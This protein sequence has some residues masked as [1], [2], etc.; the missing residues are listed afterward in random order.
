MTDERY[1]KGKIYKLISSLTTDIY[2]G[3]TILKLNERL[4]KHK[5]HYKLF[6]ENEYP[7][8][9]SFRL[10]E[11]GIDKV[12]IQLIEDYSCNCRNE[13]EIKERYWI[14]N[15][16][17]CINKLIPTRTKKEYHQANRDV[18]LKK[19]KAYKQANKKV[20]SEKA[21]VKIACECGSIINK[22]DLSKHKR[23]TKHT[24]YIT[25][26]LTNNIT[27]LTI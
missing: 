26:Q 15:T 27:Q 24:D 2:I 7:N 13:L 11:K 25:T 12:E 20:I 14:E 9:T 23:T 1:K 10:F 6:I 21:K 5:C 16:V 3:S 19:M 22:N 17:N 4:S 8:C 18:L